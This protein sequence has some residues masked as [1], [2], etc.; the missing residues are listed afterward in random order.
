MPVSILTLDLKNRR[1]V[2]AYRKHHAAVWPEV[3]RSLRRVGVID[4]EIFALGRRLV[5][6][7]D[8]KPGFNAKRDF[9]RHRESHPRVREWEK[10]MAG[11]QQAAPDAPRGALWAP[12]DHV[13][14]LRNQL[15][16]LSK[17]R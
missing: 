10:L 9:A 6:V 17:R 13:F 12:M 4:M 16:A 11:F 2:A 5:M 3:L 15:R 1:V 7:L 14:S 8:T